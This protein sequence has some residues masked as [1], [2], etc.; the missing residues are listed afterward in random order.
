MAKLTEVRS[1]RPWG[2]MLTTPAM[3][4]TTAWRQAPLLQA[5][6]T[7]PLNRSWDHT[8]TRAT[9]TMTQL[10][11]CST[12]LVPACSSLTTSEYLRASRASRWA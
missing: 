10:I 12:R 7:L 2:T 4:A 9:G 6:A 8:R 5:S 1:T 3:P 11:Q